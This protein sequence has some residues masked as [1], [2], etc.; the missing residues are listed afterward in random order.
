VSLILGSTR[1]QQCRHSAGKHAVGV[2]VLAAVSLLLSACSAP[3]GS[4][5]SGNADTEGSPIKLVW[6]HNANTDP[7]LSWYKKV[8]DDYMKAH[9][10]VV[11]EQVPLQSE[12]MKSKIRVAM[13]SNNPPDIFHQWGGGQMKEQ[14]QAGKIMDLTE[15]SASWIGELPEL[16]LKN[17]QIDGKTYGIPY[18]A[19]AIGFWYRKDLF[20]KAGITAVPT[21]YDELITTAS[22]LRASGIDPIAI[23]GKDKWP[24][25]YWYYYLVA[26]NCSP[27]VL[28]Q[29][30]ESGKFSD[31][32]WR[33]ASEDFQKVVAAGVFNRG[34]A[35]TSAQQGAGSSAGLIAN[36]KAAMELMGQ[37]NPSV[38]QS[39]TPDQK[40]LSSEALGWFPFPTVKGAAGNQEAAVGGGDGYSC[41]AK[42]PKECADFLKYFVST[43]VQKSYATVVRN[44]PANKGASAAVTEPALAQ[45][46]KLRDSAPVFQTYLD[47]TFGQA[48]GDAINESVT[49]QLVGQS[50]PDKV[51][52]D[53]QTAA[54]QNR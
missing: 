42:A 8:S 3:G 1:R 47:V 36:G 18:S 37:W 40:P 39:L 46:L 20:A 29:T 21:T 48:V 17:W 25:A 12:D 54:D 7:G 23:A 43:D 41:S 15:A 11:I 6:W 32:C 9:P 52:K 24:V 50:T 10:N 14:V 45:V 26:R 2:S 33:E 34:F 30:T 22:K 4:S 53:I 51:V 13:Q 35:G 27:D 31:T 44:L 38:I 16:V 19:G 28:R 49:N 5:G